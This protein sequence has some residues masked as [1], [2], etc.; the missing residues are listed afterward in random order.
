MRR[1]MHVIGDNLMTK[2][3][4]FKNGLSNNG[5][6]SFSVTLFS[7]ID[8]LVSNP[9]YQVAISLCVLR[10]VPPILILAKPRKRYR[11]YIMP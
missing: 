5:V 9:L 8:I 7:S 3:P 4:V 11:R 6:W 2:E 10:F 1:Y